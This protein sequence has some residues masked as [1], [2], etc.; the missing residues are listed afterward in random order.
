M[1]VVLT[2][3]RW[4]PKD[5]KFGGQKILT[6]CPRY[7]L[8]HLC[9]APPPTT[10][11]SHHIPGSHCM[12]YRKKWNG[13]HRGNRN[14]FSLS[15][16]SKPA[17]FVLGNWNELFGALAW[18]PGKTDVSCYE[19]ACCQLATLF[20]LPSIQLLRSS[21]SG[22]LKLKRFSD[23]IDSW[24]IGNTK[25]L[26]QFE[27]ISQGWFPDTTGKKEGKMVRHFFALV[28]NT[29]P[30]LMYRDAYSMSPK[31][32]MLLAFYLRHLNSLK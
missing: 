5:L 24:S 23:L 13:E 6:A 1:S 22:I 30:S 11:L 29:F 20:L 10:P 26:S 25:E 2:L 31:H 19:Q 17:V 3:G 28:V 8:C 27:K 16:F 21:I 14:T 15:V 18:L 7:T 9:H 4:K 12:L 32:L